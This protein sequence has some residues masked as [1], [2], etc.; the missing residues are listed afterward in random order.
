MLTCALV[1]GEQ[2]D[3]TVDLAPDEADA[4]LREWVALLWRSRRAP[5]LA[6]FLDHAPAVFGAFPWLP[7]ELTRL[8][9]ELAPQPD[10]IVS[11]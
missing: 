3:L 10:R 2:I 6:S 4:A 11:S 7:Q 5:L 1:L 9:R 8:T